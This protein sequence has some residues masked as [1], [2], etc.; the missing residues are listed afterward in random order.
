METDGHVTFASKR[1]ANRRKDRDSLPR[2]EAFREYL[3]KHNLTAL[4]RNPS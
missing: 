3:R 1:A 2:L 4:P